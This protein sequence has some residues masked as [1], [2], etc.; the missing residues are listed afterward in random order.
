MRIADAL[1]LDYFVLPTSLLGETDWGGL[2]EH[3]NL[4]GDGS[5][6][7]VCVFFSGEP[8]PL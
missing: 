4:T 2:V 5:S 8:L 6:Q 1:C 7:V 3:R